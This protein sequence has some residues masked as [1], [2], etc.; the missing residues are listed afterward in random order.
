[1]SPYWWDLCCD[2]CCTGLWTECGSSG[3]LDIQVFTGKHKIIC[4]TFVQ[5]WTNVEDVGPTLY[6]CYTNV[7]CM[8]GIVHHTF[9]R[10][11]PDSEATLAALVQHCGVTCCPYYVRLVIVLSGDGFTAYSGFIIYRLHFTVN[12]GSEWI[13]QY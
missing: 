12:Q 7:L 13:H 1:M 3:S 11:C 4:I 5:C 2:E 8:L 10:N 9:T 6:K